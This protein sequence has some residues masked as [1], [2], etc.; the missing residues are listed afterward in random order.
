MEQRTSTHPPEPIAVVGIGCRLPGGVES[1]DALWKVLADG[2]D[3]IVPVS[4][5][6][7]DPRRFFDPDPAAIGRGRVMEAGFLDLRLDELDA[8]FFGLSPREAEVLDPRQW[9]MLECT[10]EAFEDAAMRPSAVAGSDTGVFVGAFLNDGA[11]HRMGP[12]SRTILG[13]ALS[14]GSSQTMLAARLSYFFDLRGPSLAL[15]TA[16]SSSL[17]ATHLGCQSI[18]RGECSRALVGGVNM[19]LRPEPMIVLDKGGFLNPEARCRAFDHRAAGYV[20]GEGAAMVLLEP[21]S[22]ARAAGRRIHALICATGCNQDGHTPGITVPRL[23]AQV[24]LLDGICTEAGVPPGE[25]DFVEAHGTGTPVGD[26][27]EVAALDRVLSRGRARTRSCPIGSI[28]TNIGHLEAAAGIAGLVKACLS[29][30]RGRIAPSLQFEELNPAIDLSSGT[31]SIAREE[32][33]LEGHGPWHALVNSFGY[34]GT[35][36]AVLLRS[37]APQPTPQRAYAPGPWIVPLSGRSAESRRGQA[38]R[39]IGWLE[40][41]ADPSVAELSR[42]AFATRENHR[43]R[44]ALIVQSR[45]QLLHQLRQ[46]AAG[47]AAD[48][49]VL[50]TAAAGA[51]PVFVYTGMGAQS[52]GMADELASSEPVFRDAIARCSAI[53]RALADWPLSG[54]FE[55]GSGLRRGGREAGSPM[56]RP[57]FAQPANLA[58]QVALTLW[59]RSQGLE[60]AAV[61]G[62]S[63]GEVAAAWAAGVLSL[64]EAFQIIHARAE[65]LSRLE[66][67][68]TMMAVRHPVEQVEQLLDRPDLDVSVATWNSPLLCVAAGPRAGLTAVQPQL[69]ALGARC[70]LLSVGV[71]YHHAAIRPHEADFRRRLAGVGA[72]APQ[73]PFFST[74]TGSRLNTVPAGPEHWWRA[75]AE[76]VRLDRAVEQLRVAGHRHFLEIGP[77]PGVVPA[78]AESFAAAG[79][80]ALVFVSLRREQPARRALT[81]AKARLFVEGAWVPNEDDDR[82]GHLDLPRY[83]WHR[84]RYAR[85]TDVMTRY[86]FGTNEH[87]LL[88]ERALGP[89]LAWRSELAQGCLPWLPEHRV[90]GREILPGAALVETALAVGRELHGFPVELEELQLLQMLEPNERSLIDVSVARETGRLQVSSASLLEE[91]NWIPHARGRLVRGSAGL[92]QARLQ[93]AELRARCTEPV[94]PEELYERFEDAG[95]DYGP[96]FRCIQRLW[97]GEQ[98]VL[99]ELQIPGQADDYLVH[100]ALLDGAIQALFAAIDGARLRPHVPVAVGHT[101]LSAPVGE[102][103]LLW[104]EITA[105]TESDVVGR[106]VLATPDG[107]IRLEIGEIRYHRLRAG[108]VE[109]GL[110]YRQVWE[111]QPAPESTEAPAVEHWL[112]IE[113]QPG[114]AAELAQALTDRGQTCA[115]Q[116]LRAIASGDLRSTERVAEAAW[117]VLAGGAPDATL[118]DTTLPGATLPDTTLPGATLSDETLTDAETLADELWYAGDAQAPLVTLCRELCVAQR[119]SAR[120]F[121]V[122]DRA[123][124]IEPAD[125]SVD[126]TQRAGWGLSRVVGNEAPTVACRRIDAAPDCTAALVDELLARTDEDEVA[127][128]PGGRFVHRFVT[129]RGAA[130]GVPVVLP[131][132]TPMGLKAIGAGLSGVGFVETA[133]RPPAPDEVVCRVWLAGVNFKDVLKA[134]NRLPGDYLERCFS[135]GDLGSEFVGQVVGVGGEVGDFTVGDVVYGFARAALSTYVNIPLTSAY[136]GRRIWAPPI[137]R[138]PPDREPSDF[139]GFVNFVTAWHCL[140]T[141]ARLED[142]ETV[143]IHSAAGGVGLAAVQLAQRRG[144]RIIATAGTLEKRAHLASLGVER[145]A[146]SRSLEFADQVRAWTEG[147]GVDVVLGS[148]PGETMLASLDLLAPFGRYIDIGKSDI[149]RGGTL[150]L[151]ALDRNRTFIAFDLDL[152][153]NERSLYRSVLAVVQALEQRE[154]SPLPLQV[155]GAAEA[156]DAIRRLAKG[157][158]IGKIAVDLRAEQIPAIRRARPDGAAED[159]CVLIVGG[160]GGVGLALARWL[161]DRGAQHLVLVGRS[162]LSDYEAAEAVERLR[163]RARVR[164][165]AADTTVYASVRTMLEA[166]RAEGEPLRAVFHL[167]SVWDDQPLSGQDD[168]SFAR[169]Y[170]CKAHTAAYLH[171][172]TQDDPL[173]HFVLFSSIS[174]I[175]GNPGQA[176][177]SAANAFLDGL[178]HHRRALGMPALSVNL[179]LIGDVGVATRSAGLLELLEARGVAPL[180][181]TQALDQLGRLLEESPIQC[182]VAGFDWERLQRGW[183]LAPRFERHLSH[184]EGKRGPSGASAAVLAAL[185]ALQQAAPGQRGALATRLLVQ[186]IADLLGVDPERVDPDLSL[187]DLGLDSLMAVEFGVSLRELT[188]VELRTELIT[189]GSSLRECAQSIVAEL[190]GA[191][192]AE[193]ERR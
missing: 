62:H 184:E 182:A 64:E 91:S 67:A 21:L 48:G 2:T 172:L 144:A 105:R 92:R 6:R 132:D 8:A 99:A 98:A 102:H 3:C 147:F 170:A 107:E 140:V 141:L 10:W 150:P 104:G 23:D 89:E 75:C 156:G 190:P 179:G 9:M 40:R 19:I 133:R 130:P 70:T 152:A 5:G 63:V 14:R 169:I 94:D 74:L 29:L 142:G 44:A 114:S 45:E 97:R 168:A 139:L 88:Q 87:P 135:G 186:A 22:Q 121:L 109:T 82:G 43:F 138:V 95:F 12:L 26:P 24:A 90:G 119:S 76:P 116:D 86:L 127:L 80:R 112:L 143:L 65:V 28:K 125:P 18:W 68:G 49:L 55:P 111:P 162:G 77:H 32:A 188:G 180:S 187:M 11:V 31:L 57:A 73:R 123:F 185:S 126:P 108:L 122:T 79:D 117:V 100:P 38:P 161:V 181:I 177:Y 66:G 146:D 4:P 118:P 52:W 120:F 37:A 128:R 47:E 42:S 164:V 53:Y 1:T 35:N 83:A 85:M 115:V 51:G 124:R 151:K 171:A 148:A 167:A 25:I 178:A 69:E 96:H 13:S 60:P 173:E 176:A 103:A 15:D 136:R 174:T 110:L 33:V 175:L 145:V 41:H 155:F 166:V 56:T 153:S 39:L 34:G 7:W 189:S 46:L 163:T 165:I 30:Q 84:E 16:C 61:V 72:A 193:Q 160:L 50:G 71:P 106:L 129:A 59:W 58:L 81:A 149:L 158:Q 93:V 113:Q 157:N 78:I 154:L 131:G 159:G 36:A 183:R 54:L 101:R 134:Q 192:T 27:I 137:F 191:Q 20:R 17:V